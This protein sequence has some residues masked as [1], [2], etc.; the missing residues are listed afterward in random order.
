MPKSTTSSRRHWAARRYQAGQARQSEERGYSGDL[1][2]D[3]K[4]SVPE[5]ALVQSGRLVLEGGIR[6]LQRRA[7]PPGPDRASGRLSGSVWEPALWYRP[8]Q[9]GR[10]ADG[11]GYDDVAS[12]GPGTAWTLMAD[13]RDV[14]SERR[15]TRGVGGGASAEAK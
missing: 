9:E 14:C 6:E 1:C 12:H 10:Q 5:E 2:A 15:G 13:T 8:G 3:P 11:A 4:P 7:G